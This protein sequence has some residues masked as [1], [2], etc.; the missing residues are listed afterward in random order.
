AISLFLLAPYV[1]AEA[2][3][4]LIGVLLP[5]HPG[6]VSVSRSARW[7]FAHGSGLR[8]SGSARSSGRGPL[9]ARGHKMCCVPPWQE[10]FWSASPPTPCSVFGGL[11][12]L[13]RF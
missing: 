5:R 7:R 2:I 9:T 10:R 8:S 13:W 11:I 1:A 4:T 12:Q 6:S 3:E